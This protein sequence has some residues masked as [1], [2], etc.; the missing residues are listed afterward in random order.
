MPPRLALATSPYLRQHAGNPVDWYPWGDEASARARAEDKPLL[1]SIGYSACHWCHV[2]AHECFEDAEV[3]AAMNRDFVNVKVDRE[4]RPDVDRIYQTAHALLARRGGGWPLTVFATP[5]GDPFYIGTYFPKEARHGLPGFLDLLPRVAAL[6]RERRGAIAAQG[7]EVRRALASLEPSPAASDAWP[8]DAPRRL[9]DELAAAFDERLGGFDG[10]PKFPQAPDLAFALRQGALRGTQVGT[11]IASVTA[12][13]MADGGIHDQLGGG[14]CRYATD[15]RWAI[16]HF[17]KMLGDNAMLLGLY[18]DVAAIAG[19]DDRD[20][21]VRAA[22][23]IVAWLVREMRAPDGA[24]FSSLDADS[25]GEEGRHYLWTPG[26]VRALLTPDEF[27]VASAHWGLDRAPNFEGRAWHLVVARPLSD[28]AASLALDP[29]VARQ[30]LEAARTAL[31]RARARRVPPA[32]D[33]K[34]LTSWNALA[35]A[36]LARASRRLQRP[37]W[38]D[39]A[40]AALDAQKRFAWQGGRLLATRH[41]ERAALGAYLDDHAYMLVALDE[42]MQARFRLADYAFARALADALLA[43]FEDP[44]DG[45]FWFTSHDHEALIHRGKPGHD[46]ATPSGN[47]MA[48]LGLASLGGLAGEP[49]YAEAARRAVRLFAAQL[50]SS[51][52]GFATLAS[53][54]DALEH[55]PATVLLVGDPARTAAWHAAIARDPSVDAHVY[56]VGTLALPAELRKGPQEAVPVAAWVCEGTRCLPPATTL[57][58]LRSLLAARRREAA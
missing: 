44:R 55:P 29:G 16:P 5:G 18:A 19:G 49:R 12:R 30:R 6:W 48:A 41:G 51:P 39:L 14:F 27:A 57:P 36:G 56:D 38:A 21:C 11:A 10:A 22:E 37:D 53:A 42:A 23:G 3:A 9:L 8:A 35:I 4:E 15:A 46:D 31:L 47:G 20:A 34:I 2:M 26:E 7:D 32:R 1:V 24:Y 50:A 28:V 13:R 45:G 54:V 17:E 52:R 40:F 43:R 33:D 25:E 58:A